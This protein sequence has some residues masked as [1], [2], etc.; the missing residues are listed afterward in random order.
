MKIIF[1]QT[2]GTIDKDYPKSK[3]G[4]GFEIGDSALKNLLNKLPLSFDYQVDS[5]LKKDSTEINDKDLVKIYKSCESYK[6]DKIIITH[7]TDTILNTASYLSKIK[8]KTIVLTGSF[9]PYN[10]KNTDADFNIGLAVA[11]IQTL[12][13]GIYVSLNGQIGKFNEFQRNEQNGRY[14]IH[15]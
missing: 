13:H 12:S 7:G 15:T 8:D 14:F 3:N 1:L 4:W 5:I 9:L 6:E 10:F 11:G 2:G